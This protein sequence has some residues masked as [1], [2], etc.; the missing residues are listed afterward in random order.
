MSIAQLKGKTVPIKLWTRIE[1]VESA[2]LTQLK[3][4]AA[5]PWC[6]KHVAVMPDV[7]LGKGA[8][9]GSVV[10]MKDAIAPAAVGVDI[11]CGMAAQL[12]SLTSRSSERA[13]I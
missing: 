10:A 4:I 2:A 11:G 5:L 1:E 7:H 12:T 9:V 6:F 8:T 13:A 3:N